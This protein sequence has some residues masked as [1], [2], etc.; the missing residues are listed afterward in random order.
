[1]YRYSPLTWK[2]DS[3]P[4]STYVH[5]RA[6]STQYTGWHFTAHVRPALPPPIRGVLWFGPDDTKVS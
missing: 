3:D 4:K 1:M 6:I 2:L 5:E